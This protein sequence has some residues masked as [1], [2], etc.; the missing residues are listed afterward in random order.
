MLSLAQKF[1]YPT[2]LPGQ[3]KHN[4]KSGWVREA[5]SNIITS[6][7]WENATFQK[8]EQQCPFVLQMLSTPCSLVACP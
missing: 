5:G 4:L 1:A 2:S 3:P 8:L 7:E 6:L